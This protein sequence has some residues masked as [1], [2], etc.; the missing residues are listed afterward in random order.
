MLLTTDHQAYEAKADRIAGRNNP[1]MMLGAV[2]TTRS[3][4]ARTTC[5]RWMRKH[6]T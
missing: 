5:Q 3:V 2:R 6:R 4:A 1:A